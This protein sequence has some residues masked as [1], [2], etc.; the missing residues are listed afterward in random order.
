MARKIVTE[1][2]F[3]PITLEQFKRHAG[4]YIDDEDSDN[5]SRIRAARMEAESLSNRVL[6]DS[7]WELRLDK[8]PDDNKRIVGIKAPLIAIDWIKY[9]DTSGT[10][11]TLSS[12]RYQV[13][14]FSEPPRVVPA[15]GYSWPATRDELNAVRVQ[16]RAGYATAGD[17]P[18][19][20]RALVAGIAATLVNFREFVITGT[21]RT[22]I[23]TLL[24]RLE[25]RDTVF[26]GDE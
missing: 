18:D 14:T 21:I 22:E 17:I 25:F 9:V 6:C 11:Q 4:I 5:K 10:L 12:S 15:F 20:I 23:D 19:T 1:P 24:N 13:D 16:F 26:E 3:E 7:V 8:F 2:T